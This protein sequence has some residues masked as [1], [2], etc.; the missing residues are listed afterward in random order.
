MRK[1][2]FLLLGWLS[3]Q[4]IYGQNITYM[5][6]FVDTDT[7]YGNGTPISFTPASVVTTNFSVNI[8][9]TLTEGFHFLSVRVKDENSRWSIVALKPF[10]NQIIP[11]STMANISTIEYFIDND[12]GYDNGTSISF[13]EGAT[14]AQTFQVAIPSEL[15]DGFHVLSLRA[16]NA[17]NRWTMVGIRP[18][19][20]QSFLNNSLPN[21]VAIEY[22]IDTDPGLGNGTSV[23]I[24]EGIS[25]SR[26]FL[27]DLN[28][29]TNGNHTL[30]LRAND[31]NNRWS[32]LAI[33][34]FT[35]QD[36]IIIIQNMAAQ[37]CVNTNFNIPL[38]LYGA[39]S[40]GNI[41]TA[42]LSDSNGSFASPTNIG[43]LSG[44]ATG[45]I[46]ANI[47]DTVSEGSGYRIRV[48]S[49]EPAVENSPDKK[50]E[51]LSVCPPPC[52]G[53][54]TLESWDDDYIYGTVLKEVS[55]STGTIIASNQVRNNVNVTFRVGK[56]ITLNPGFVV[57][58]G[59]VFKTEFGGCN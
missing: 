43:T 13:S 9:G 28:G 38:V 52:P 24:T 14:V 54:L 46:V 5:E 11:D 3:I 47:P 37:W 29:L 32:Q 41:F 22:F 53:I 21:I 6:Y 36:N 25:V 1:L 20:K 50:F 39:Y 18:F 26:N 2:R 56:S 19:Y 59:A 48:I 17:D 15:P 30:Y 34:D 12:P 31:A 55:A 35:V 4:S 57:N 58:N 16:K 33:R 10:Y 27:L 45:T 51:L 8:S 7:G 49:S 42:Q 23:A 44:T 40:V